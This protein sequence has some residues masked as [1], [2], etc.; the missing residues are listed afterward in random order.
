MIRFSLLSSCMDWWSLHILSYWVV[1][2]SLKH[3]KY[4]HHDPGFEDEL[5]IFGIDMLHMCI[6]YF[7][8]NELLI[9]GIDM[10]RCII[11]VKIQLEIVV[12]STIDD[13][14][15]TACFTSF[16]KSRLKLLFSTLGCMVTYIC[17]KQNKMYVPRLCLWP[18]Q[19][20]LKCTKVVWLSTRPTG[21]WANMWWDGT[22]W[23][24]N[25]FHGFLQ[26]YNNVCF[27]MRDLRGINKFILKFCIFSWHLTN[28]N[29][30]D[31]F[32]IWLDQLV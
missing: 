14:L 31:L 7:L 18:I 20:V 16:L 23:W 25:L 30:I 22:P 6:C 29:H 5:L 9:F 8:D 4:L 11:Q 26:Q 24:W 27:Q 21:I 19:R 2:M 3:D 10:L 1:C 13:I 32:T 17:R 28:K 12:L 15:R